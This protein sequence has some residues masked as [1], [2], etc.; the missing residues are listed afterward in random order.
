[1]ETT[2]ICGCRKQLHAELSFMSFHF[3]CLRWHS[4][5]LLPLFLY[6]LF[7]VAN[8]KQK[9]QSAWQSQHIH[10]MSKRFKMPSMKMRMRK[11]MQ[12][13]MKMRGGSNHIRNHFSFYLSWLF[14]SFSLALF[15]SIS[16]FCWFFPV[17]LR[18]RLCNW[19]RMC[20][21]SETAG[22][23]MNPG[24]QNKTKLYVAVPSSECVQ[25][26]QMSI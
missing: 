1:M 6:R 11:R 12:K 26:Y 2:C 24:K 20:W 13:Q 21:T 4:L 22:K 23:R 10:G 14:L 15:L 7:C 8:K 17:N 16:P 5:L 25:L 19:T 9:M 18:K 3:N